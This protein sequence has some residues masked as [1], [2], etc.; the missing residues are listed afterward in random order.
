MSTAGIV[1]GS[2]AALLSEGGV[3]GQKA[4]Q[5]GGGLALASRAPPNGTVGEAPS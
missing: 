2:R 1:P 3:Q 4:G 5:G